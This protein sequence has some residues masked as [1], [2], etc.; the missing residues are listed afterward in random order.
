MN[1]ITVPHPVCL[2]FP[3]VADYT[4]KKYTPPLFLSGTPTRGVSIE[5]K[6]I[7]LAA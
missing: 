6:E 7:K 4:A 1:L 3:N 5:I 2:R